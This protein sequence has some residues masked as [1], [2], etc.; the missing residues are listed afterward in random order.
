MQLAASKDRLT[1][2]AQRLGLRGLDELLEKARLSAPYTHP[3]MNR[4]YGSLAFKVSAEGLEAVAG[5]EAKGLWPLPGKGARIRLLC[6]MC[7][8]DGMACSWCDGRGYVVTVPM[9]VTKASLLYERKP[10]VDD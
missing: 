10:Q 9:A 1:R 3:V 7:L 8:A 6:E 5:I 4:R 2:A